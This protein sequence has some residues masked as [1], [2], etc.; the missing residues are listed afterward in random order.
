MRPAATAT[1]GMPQAMASSIYQA[2]GFLIAPCSSASAL[3]ISRATCW[4]G[5]NPSITVT[6]SG[7]LAGM[8]EP[9]NSKW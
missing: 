8:P 6:L 1:T 5:R 3:A 9:T 2:E 4:A 7:T